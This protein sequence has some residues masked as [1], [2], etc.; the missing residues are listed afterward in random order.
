[1]D[2]VR[3]NKILE[4]LLDKGG[5]VKKLKHTK[6][7]WGFDSFGIFKKE[8][9]IAPSLSNAEYGCGRI[10][11]ADARLIAAAPEMLEALIESV[12]EGFAL[13]RKYKAELPADW[14]EDKRVVAIEKATGLKIKEVIGGRDE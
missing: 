5:D 2:K 14:K 12:K 6:G 4:T 13:V 10:K 1:L 9:I 11:E 8:Y 3:K 7:P